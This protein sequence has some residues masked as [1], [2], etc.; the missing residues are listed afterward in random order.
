M[1]PARMAALHR[2]GFTT[3]PPWSEEDFADLLGQPGVLCEATE[4]AFA[5][6]RVTVDEA[7]LLTITTA[8]EARGRGM[9]VALLTRLLG[10]AASAGARSCFLEV[11]AD[12]TAA[13]RLYARFGFRQV[14]LRPRY[15]RAPDG[16]AQDARVL[17][18]DLPMDAATAQRRDPGAPESY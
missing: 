4:T 10:R 5:L 11:A 14:G 9:A 13:C 2:V 3:P 12:N 16:T 6:L 17:V 18:R 15:Y 1:T 8:P 7:E